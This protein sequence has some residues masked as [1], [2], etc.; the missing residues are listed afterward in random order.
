MEAPSRR[1]PH[2]LQWRE[3]GKVKTKSF[4]AIEDRETH[5]KKLVFARDVGERVVYALTAQ[6]VIEYREAKEQ[7]GWRDLRLVV[8][9]LERVSVK[10]EPVL[11]SEACR[12]LESMRET[13]ALSADAKS[14]VRLHLKRLAEKLGRKILDE[15]T[16]DDLRAWLASLKGMDPYTL[17]H[18]LKSARLLFSTAI[19]E[20]WCG[21]N[22]ADSVPIP[23]IQ[24]E[25]ITVLSLEDAQKLFA[26][27]RD[28]LCVGRLA[29]EAFGGL[30]YTSAARLTRNE[31]LDKELGIV[32][33]AG[34]H[35]TGRRH[36]VDG[37][38]DNLWQWIAHAPRACWDVAQ[39]QYLDYKA[40]MFAAAKIKN[41]GNVLRH[42]FCSYHVALH[43]D[44]AR[45]AVL[46]T[47]RSPSMLYQHYRG[48]A[49]EAD[50]KAY[51]AIVP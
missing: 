35:K 45:T 42:S 33:S 16:P 38:P 46:L 28:R 43:K 11:L 18:H 24:S 5:A 27:N 50:A 6:E 21:M 37:Y 30:R 1:K 29:L 12:R 8:A 10:R 31:I 32:M 23:K 19:R 9:D 13:S 44:A 39:R 40:E 25:D 41:P 49:S 7:A 3:A 48:R 2:L 36:Y 26:V 14:H 4:A 51:F 22:P 20:K 15:V 17:R 34:K 47:H